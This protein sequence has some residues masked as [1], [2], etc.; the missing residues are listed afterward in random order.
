MSLCTT[1]EEESV[2]VKD[3]DSSVKASETKEGA[4]VV[5]DDDGPPLPKCPR[6]CESSSSV[7]GKRANFN[8]QNISLGLSGGGHT[9]N[10][11]VLNFEDIQKIRR[12]NSISNLPLR[13]NNAHV[14]F[15]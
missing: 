7:R 14:A 13:L 8:G 3:E 5:L 10:S 4:S 12:F 9:E 11:I 15:F 6:I 2:G 1:E